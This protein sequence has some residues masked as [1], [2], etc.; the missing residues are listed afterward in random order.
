MN[1]DF[2][3]VGCEA[4][5][6]EGRIYHGECDDGY[7]EPCPYCEGTGGEIIPVEPVTIDDLLATPL[8]PEATRRLLTALTNLA[9]EMRFLLRQNPEKDGG[10]YRQRLDEADA[11]IAKASA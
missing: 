3:I 8:N 11:A 7:S 10:L 6:T 1:E 2:R 9:H 4:C 5:G